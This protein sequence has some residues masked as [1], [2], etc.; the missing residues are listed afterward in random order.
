MTIMRVRRTLSE[1]E[2]ERY[3]RVSSVIWVVLVSL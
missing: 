2:S 3:D 1:A